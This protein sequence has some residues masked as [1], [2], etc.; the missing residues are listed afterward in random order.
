MLL[1]GHGESI[2]STSFR[3][4]HDDNQKDGIEDELKEN[5][6]EIQNLKL[7]TIGP[8]L[9]QPRFTHE[10]IKSSDSRI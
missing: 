1:S 8:L 4:L 5:G 9:K 6:P 10:E 2:E 7:E 3:D